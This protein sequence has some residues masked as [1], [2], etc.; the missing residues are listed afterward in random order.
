M[1]HTGSQPNRA[2]HRDLVK[3]LPG[4]HMDKVV[5]CVIMSWT[6]KILSLSHAAKMAMSPGSGL[7]NGHCS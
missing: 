4:C 2:G 3:Q 5:G 1:K 7:L 6:S